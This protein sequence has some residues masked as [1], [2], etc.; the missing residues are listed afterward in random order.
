M[1]IEY[2]NFFPVNTKNTLYESWYD[3]ALDPEPQPYTWGG[4]ESVHI[5][6]RDPDL[7]IYYSDPS[8]YKSR[9]GTE[10]TLYKAGIQYE[11]ILARDP[12]PNI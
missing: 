8:I 6:A 12:D 11:H 7:S 1:D 3:R 9:S 5:H 4:S 2:R 10:H